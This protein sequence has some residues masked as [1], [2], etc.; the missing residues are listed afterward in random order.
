[1]QISTGTSELRDITKME[2]IGAYSVLI[3]CLNYLRLLC[4]RPLAHP[5]SRARRPPRAPRQRAG[6]RRPGQGAQGRRHDPQNGAGGQDRR[7]RNALRWPALHR[8]DGH[9][10]GCVLPFSYH[11]WGSLFFYGH[12]RYHSCF[13]SLR[14]GTSRD[15]YLLYTVSKLF[16]DALVMTS[17]SAH[18]S[19]AQPI[20]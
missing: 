3:Q 13:R 11:C 1:M 16:A 15:T 7:P 8:Q 4:R 2:R 9:C 18:V 10:S 19:S 14:C 12:N 17:S 20:G 5:R 6:P